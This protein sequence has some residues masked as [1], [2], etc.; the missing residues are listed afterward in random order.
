MGL[1]WLK[2]KDN[3]NITINFKNNKPQGA[4]SNHLHFL[5]NTKNAIHIPENTTKVTYFSKKGIRN[6]YW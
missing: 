1:R 4:L 5:W 6:A 2:I 3:A